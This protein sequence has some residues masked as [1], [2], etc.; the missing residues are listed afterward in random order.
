M[1]IIVIGATGTIGRAVAD[2]LAARHEVV[3]ASRSGE[4]SVDIE[5][6]ASVR[7]FFAEPRG[8]DA[9]VVC[10]GGGAFAPLAS[11][12]D[13][14]Y[15]Y[16]LSSKLMGQV[17]VARAAMDVLRD[18]GSIT[19]TSGVLARQP[20]KGAAA[21]SMANAGL[22]GFVIS[23]ALEMP[24]G[25]RL[26]VVSQPWIDTTLAK[27]GM[28]P[29]GGVSAEAAARAYVATVDGQVNGAIVPVAS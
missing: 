14:Q 29:S 28:D 1:K 7:A 25:L 9:V 16:G 10:A 5:K 3:R 19:L 24:R 11:L 4:P 17:N 18:G 23:A 22:E 2:A 15:A 8:A 27:L 26:N 13:E 12:T 21:I 20:I 6:P